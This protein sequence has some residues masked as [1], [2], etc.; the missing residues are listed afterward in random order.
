MR[1]LVATRSEHKLSEIRRI[2]A[3]VPGLELVEPLR[4][5]L[6]EMAEEEGIEVFETFEENAMAKARWFRERSGMVVLADDS[7]L[8]VDALRGEPGVRSKRFAP[9][10]RSGEGVDQA[11]NRCLLE[12]LAGVAPEAR[13][14]R[15]VCVAVLDPGPAGPAQPLVVRGEA[16]G[17]ILD[18][19]VGEGGFGYDPLFHDIEVGRAFAQLSEEEKDARS[20]RGKA[21]RELA[22]RMT[23]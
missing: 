9:D 2:L 8:M 15:F 16:E 5:G 6:P 18:A 10:R 22:G 4:V 1:V 13:T 3:S 20:H 23:T 7:G 12:R 19:P 11:N 21:F 17:L 14:A